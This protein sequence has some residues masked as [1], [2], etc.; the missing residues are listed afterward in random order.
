MGMLERRQKRRSGDWGTAISVVAAALCWVF[1]GSQS[2][3]HAGGLL[4]VLTRHHCEVA[5]RLNAIRNYPRQSGEKDWSKRRFL[6]LSPRRQPNYYVQ[7]IFFDEGRSVLCEASSGVFAPAKVKAMLFPLS[8]EAVSK[9]RE[10]GF[11]GD[12]KTANYSFERP[13]ENGG[14]EAIADIMLKS[15]HGAFG[16]EADASLQFVSPLAPS[17]KAECTPAS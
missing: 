7:C 5:T 14:V 1:D 16:L 15:L 10:L 11:G 12:G 8:Q 13:V 17:F 3:A 6:I 2:G 9:L 4:D